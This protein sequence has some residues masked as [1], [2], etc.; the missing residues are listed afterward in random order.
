ML[1]ADRL[2]DLDHS[3][4]EQEEL[5]KAMNEKIKTLQKESEIEIKSKTI[6][7]ENIDNESIMSLN[8]KTVSTVL[9]VADRIRNQPQNY[10]ESQDLGSKIQ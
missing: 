3:F 10:F 9:N 5:N 4:R 2:N 6:I 7:R 1:L 8:K